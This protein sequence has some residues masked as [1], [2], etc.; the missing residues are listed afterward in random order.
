MKTSVLA[1]DNQATRNRTSRPLSY[2]GAYDNMNEH[3]PTMTMPS[4]HE[5][6]AY[7][8]YGSGMSSERG[9]FTVG[10]FT[11]SQGQVGT[12]VTVALTLNFQI[13]GRIYIRLAAGP[14]QLETKV[15]RSCQSSDDPGAQDWVIQA[16]MP[17][18]D[19]PAGSS[20]A[21]P[22]TVQILTDQKLLD[23]ASCGYFTY[24]TPGMISL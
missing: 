11:P 6:P 22:I 10:S 12:V 4:P 1:G 15:S 5:A 17:P 24:T 8:V 16:A 19:D 2:R 21:A 23:L 14:M 18:C 9:M 20:V 3:P 7:A 13:Q